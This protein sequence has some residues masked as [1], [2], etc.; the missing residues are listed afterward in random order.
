MT[1]RKSLVLDAN[2]LIR[3][4]FGARVRILLESY[5]NSAVFYAPDLCFDDA[6]QYIP[7]IA[8]KRNFDPQ[9]GLVVLQGLRGIVES[10]DRSLYGIHEKEATRRIGSRD[11]ADWPILA[12]A[13]LLECPIWTEDQDFFGSGVATWTTQTVELY[14]GG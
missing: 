2:I 4:I 1:A 13:L 11:G 12:T 5:E 10:V 9:T 14:L 6:Q 8:R 7:E 3:A